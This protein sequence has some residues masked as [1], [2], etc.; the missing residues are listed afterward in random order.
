MCISAPEQSRFLVKFTL[1]F[2]VPRNAF[3][4][5]GK[6]ALLEKLSSL[7]IWVSILLQ[8]SELVLMCTFRV[9]YHITICLFLI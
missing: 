4:L 1:D 5:L 6:M 8:W 3:S 9:S 7:L 2:V